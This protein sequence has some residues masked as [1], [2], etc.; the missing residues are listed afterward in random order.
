MD[1]ARTLRD[2]SPL[3]IQLITPV[4]KRCV[5]IASSNIFNNLELAKKRIQLS[6]LPSL[7]VLYRKEFQEATQR[8]IT[9]SSVLIFCEFIPKTL[10]MSNNKGNWPHSGHGNLVTKPLVHGNLVTK[11]QFSFQ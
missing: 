8:V 2:L 9:G 10:C 3:F 11:P 1:L 7:F 4:Q 5:Y 6:V